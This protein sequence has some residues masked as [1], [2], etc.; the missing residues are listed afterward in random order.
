MTPHRH[1][2]SPDTGRFVDFEDIRRATGA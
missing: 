2:V 1:W